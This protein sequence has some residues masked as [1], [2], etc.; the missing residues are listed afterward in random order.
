MPFRQRVLIE[1]GVSKDDAQAQREIRRRDSAYSA[2]MQRMFGFT[3]I[4]TANYALALNTAR[5]PVA[6]FGQFRMDG[7]ARA[8]NGFEFDPPLRRHE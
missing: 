5:I 7:N 1:R 2:V 3:G 4:E 6:L 8:A